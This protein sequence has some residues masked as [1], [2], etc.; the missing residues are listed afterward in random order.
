MHPDGKRVFTRTVT[1][2]AVV[3][4]LA[5]SVVQGWRHAE[6]LAAAWDVW[7]SLLLPAALATRSAVAGGRNRSVRLALSFVLT[8]LL[9]LPPPAGLLI[10]AGAL[11]V[12]GGG[13]LAGPRGKGR[14]H[15]IAV[16]FAVAAVGS[17]PLAGAQPIAFPS[18]RALALLAFMFA[19]I[20]GVALT[21]FLGLDGR[22]GLGRT[23][24]GFRPSRWLLLEAI[25][26]PL[27][28]LLIGLL[29]QSSWLPFAAFTG[30][31]LLAGH[32]LRKLDRALAELRRINDALGARATE[33]ATLHAIGRE[34]VSSLDTSRVFSI[35]DRECGKIFDVDFFS[36]ALADRDG[37]ALRSLY[38]RRRGEPAQLEPLPLGDELASSVVRH[39]Q[40][41]KIDDLAREPWSLERLPGPPPPRIRSALVVPLVIE[42]RVIGVLSV[43]SRKHRAYDGHQLAV[44]ATIAQQAAVAIENARHYEMATVDSLTGL[45]L[46]DYFFRRLAE[47]YRRVG[48]YGGN[49]A[50]LMIDV[51]GFKAI[52]DLYGHL[53]GD[54]YLQAVGGAIGERLRGADLACR[55]GGDEFCLLLPETDLEGARAI[56]E[57]LRH[58]ISRMAV[59][60]DGQL[61]RTT[62]SIGLATFR[63]HDSGSL[64]ALIRK[65]DQALYQAKHR[66]RDRVVPYAA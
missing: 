41:L 48:R 5:I 7:L 46:R 47:E 4:A 15:F 29:Q 24:K 8:G 9:L 58:S 51:D 39:E 62:V 61:L 59:E 21:S 27:A 3:V 10:A 38:R 56:A 57:R 43:Q 20:Q 2:A 26:V 22:G 44:L 54:H 60:V 17:A 6:A 18:V 53:A 36:I 1:T 55:Y 50:M 35:I 49:L 52:N 63:D 65:S 23:V 14:R 19:L 33:L 31:V 16:L 64:R 28:F 34:I 25:N 45:F 37:S 40:G 13:G 42:D 32:L 11:A 30:L 12:G 66:G